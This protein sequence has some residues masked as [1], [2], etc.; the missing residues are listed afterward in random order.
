MQ[1]TT[2]IRA[3]AVLAV[4]GGL[5]TAY[6]QGPPDVSIPGGTDLLGEPF[7]GPGA[8][9]GATVSGAWF[10]VQ[11]EPGSV[12]DGPG[13]NRLLVENQA[14]GPDGYIYTAGG[15]NEGD[16][17]LNIGPGLPD[18]PRSQLDGAGGFWDDF[19]GSPPGAT[20]GEGRLSLPDG[21]PTYGWAAHPFL[22]VFAV[23]IANNG[24]DNQDTVFG[25][26]VGTLYA[27]GGI[28]FDDFRGGIGYSPVDG[29]HR[30]GDD[31]AYLSFYWVGT[32]TEAVVDFSVTLFPYEQGWIGGAVATAQ[33][34]GS[35]ETAWIDGSGGPYA[36]PDLDSDVVTWDS[37][38]AVSTG[39]IDLPDGATPDNGM[40]LTAYNG[41]TNAAS[42]IGVLPDGDGWKF[43]LRDDDTI[44]TDGDS[45]RTLDGQSRFSFVYVPY[46]AANFTGGLIDGETGDLLAG[47]GVTVT[48]TGDGV[49]EIEVPGKDKTTGSVALQIAGSVPTD[50]TLPDYAFVNYDFDSDKSVFV[51]NTRELTFGDNI[52]GEGT[53]LRDADF[54]FLYNDF[55]N[56]I[57]LSASCR[58][59]LDGDGELTIF[60]FLQFQNLF[61]AGDLTADFDGDGELTIF[62]FL[63]F[64]NEF[65]AGCP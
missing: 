59:D 28:T 18:D 6:G 22:G 30:N 45:F 37:P 32:A 60:D 1:T 65:D 46:D 31:S 36:S 56:P 42:T 43:A 63:A 23:A 44:D 26:P 15:T 13:S 64:Q 8:W 33:A 12:L 17:D 9:P 21:P 19:R 5:G 25:E 48:R 16:V 41:S 4:V 49:Y 27:T 20:P 11:L 14:W 52:F 53:L 57:S 2:I 50:P 35:G 24:R 51:V 10:N 39:R 40:L 62:D 54:Y 3:A 29:T 61:D 55:E 58:A 7:S 34:A 47:G 38:F